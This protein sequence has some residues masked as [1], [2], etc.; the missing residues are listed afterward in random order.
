ME[1]KRGRK[2]NY[3]EEMKAEAVRLCE[4]D[5]RSQNQ[6]ASSLGISQTSLNRWVKEARQSQNP[7]STVIDPIT[8]EK[9]RK[10]EEENRRLRLE[11]DILKKAAAFFAKN[12]S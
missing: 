3:S 1:K 10:L 4:T 8:A 5:G 6:I 12:Q 11:H 9:L 7:T 2:G